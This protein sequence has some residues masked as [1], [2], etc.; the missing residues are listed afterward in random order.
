MHKRE[1]DFS[2]FLLTSALDHCTWSY[3]ANHEVIKLGATLA[4][5]DDSVVDEPSGGAWR[6]SSLAFAISLV[7][8]CQMA[9]LLATQVSRT[10]G[11]RPGV[12]STEQWG[13][14]V[15]RFSIHR[16]G[17]LQHSLRTRFSQ[18]LLNLLQRPKPEFLSGPSPS[19]PKEA[20]RL[21]RR[22]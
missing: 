21:S 8:C 19:P 18:G 6:S 16:G 12:E 4:V 5:L 1:L 17:I 2:L 10:S 7:T 14:L 20:M 13:T 22:V 9:S 11:P 3:E 15:P